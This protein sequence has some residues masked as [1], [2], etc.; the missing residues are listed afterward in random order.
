MFNKISNLSN[1]ALNSFAKLLTESKSDKSKAM[2]WHLSFP[3]FSYNS[4]R[5]D[6]VLPKS[7]Q[8]KIKVAF[9][10]AKTLAV[11]FPIPVLAP[12]ITTT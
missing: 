11:S 9:Y 2:K 10:S 4:S 1:L 6:L 5:I 12:V 3:Y 7:L 8:A